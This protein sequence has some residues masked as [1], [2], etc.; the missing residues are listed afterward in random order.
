M[1]ILQYGEMFNSIMI[2]K[3]NLE[4][5]EDSFDSIIGRKMNLENKEDS[6]YHCVLNK[7]LYAV[8][9]FLEL[10]P[11][12]SSTL[13]TALN[14]CIK[15]H[16]G[17]PIILLLLK[18]G[19]QITTDESTLIC[20]P[21]NL[22]IDY[23]SNISFSNMEHSVLI[24]LLKHSCFTEKKWNRV[25]SDI[26]VKQFNEMDIYHLLINT[27]S[28]DHKIVWTQLF[29]YIN[30]NASLT[31]RL[32]LHAGLI[33]K[34]DF[35]DYLMDNLILDTTKIKLFYAI[36]NGEYGKHNSDIIDII[37]LKKSTGYYT[38]RSEMHILVC[39][40]TESSDILAKIEYWLT[41]IS[42]LC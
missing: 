27:V 34:W 9:L 38:I 42:N 10:D 3:M 14:M 6:F 17:T 19:A 8:N 22:F 30:N 31:Y 41:V 1:N 39:P 33:T 25:M 12:D 2:R 23:T 13:N 11:I 37:Q 15:N 20:L 36:T 5:K 26:D 28:V 16:G 32:L 35:C 24:E 29:P 21:E 4:N 40:L 7:N 18:H